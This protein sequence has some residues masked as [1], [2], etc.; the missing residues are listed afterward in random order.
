M[1]VLDTDDLISVTEANRVG[2]SG[3]IKDAESG[4][5][6]VVLRNNK[7]VAA[8]VGIE[9][10]EEAQH[11]HEDLTDISLVA[12]RMLTT[13]DRRFS[14]DEVLTAFGYSRDDLG[15]RDDEDESV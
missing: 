9:Y 7:P 3:L 2:L 1:A 13:G 6:R 12:A 5:K 4:R 14:V 11:L 10:L 8:I 15:E